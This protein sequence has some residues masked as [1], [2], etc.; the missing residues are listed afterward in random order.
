MKA[1]SVNEQGFK[2]KGIEKTFS[3]WRDFQPGINA[4]DA[5]THWLYYVKGDFI[6]QIWGGTYLEKHLQDKL[7][8]LAK[9]VGYYSAAV[10]IKFSRE[11]DKENQ[12]KLYTYILKT[13]NNKW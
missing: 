9:D 5:F 13:H 8:G 10:L 12:Q 2:K 7:M 6:N 1:K 11:L 4:I 3:D